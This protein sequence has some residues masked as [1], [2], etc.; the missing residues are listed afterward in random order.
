MLN[1]W[2]CVLFQMS[3]GPVFGFAM[4]SMQTVKENAPPKWVRVGIWVAVTFVSAVFNVFWRD[5]STPV[6]F[7]SVLLIFIAVVIGR[8]LFYKTNFLRQLSITFI[9]IVAAG[10]AE[11]IRVPIMWLLRIS[12]VSVDYSHSDMM[13]TVLVGSFVSNI[14]VFFTAVL[15]RR[16]NLQ[17]RMPRGSWAFVLMPLCLFVPTTIYCMEIVRNNGVFSPL[18]IIL[19]SG[20]L[21]LNLLL[22][23]VQFNQA[24]KEAVEKE[25]SALKHQ[26]ELE[27]QHY[28]SVET[29]REEM[30]KIRHDYNNHLSSILALLHMEKRDEA[31]QM[32]E[33]LLAKV[34]QTREYPYCGIPI[35]NAILSEKEAECYKKGIDFRTDLL[36]PE[37]VAIAPIDLCSIFANL[38]DNAIR[39]CVQLTPGQ[40]RKIE[41]N[42]AVQ[43]DYLLVR[44]DN[45]A[46]KAP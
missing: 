16:F 4:D 10:S 22:I 7:M 36:F 17:K 33:S 45:P 44:C 42:V 23:C 12:I 15:W 35:V 13:L 18:H 6:N 8:R 34:E 21:L 39:A 31:E 1:Q 26:T 28:Q 41:L 32:L 25:L 27:R 14:F 5:L 20:A 38:L 46:V 43:G 11:L 29:R 2:L 30:A 37:D 3:V 19:M 9:L 40:P 24:E